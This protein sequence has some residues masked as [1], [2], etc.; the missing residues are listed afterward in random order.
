M[1]RDRWEE[2]PSLASDIELVNPLSNAS[3]SKTLS[4]KALSYYKEKLEGH[5]A[6]L[7]AHF[8]EHNIKY[9]KVYEASEVTEKLEQ[10]FYF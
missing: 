7:Y 8:H 3:I 1:V 5:D 9:T 6:K 4:K 2:N 10:L